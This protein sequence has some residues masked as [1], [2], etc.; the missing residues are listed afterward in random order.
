MTPFANGIWWMKVGL[1]QYWDTRGLRSHRW[2][3][4]LITDI[5]VRVHDLCNMSILGGGSGAERIGSRSAWTL[6]EWL[7]HVWYGSFG[8]W[9]GTTDTRCM[10]DS[11]Q[12]VRMFAGGGVG[13]DPYGGECY[14]VLCVESHQWW[15]GLA[16]GQ[17]F[18]GHWSGWADPVWVILGCCSDDG[19]WVC[20]VAYV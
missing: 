19:V 11:R 7:Y 5:H 2:D 9:V 8:F 10:G 13:D 6:S 20:P 4:S 17:R 3:N 18:L 16:V 15:T 14:F 1:V 12:G